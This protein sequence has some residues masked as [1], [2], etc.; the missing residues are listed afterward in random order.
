MN[1]TDHLKTTSYQERLDSKTQVSP[2]LQFLN[3]ELRAQVT[4]TVDQEYPSLFAGLP[5]GESLFIEREGQVV[6]HVGLVIRQFTHPFFRIKIGLLG[7]VVTRK[8]N[9]GEGLA[10]YLLQE[11]HRKLHKDQCALSIL[12]SDQPDFY[13]ALGFCRAGNEWDFRLSLEKA[14]EAPEVSRPLNTDCEIEA[15]WNLYQAKTAKIERTLEE[16][17]ALVNIPKTRIYVTE[18]N[19]QIDSYIAINKGADFTHYVHEWAGSVEAVKRNVLDCQNRFFSGFP[20]TL[21]APLEQSSTEFSRIAE[22]E[23]KGA[24]GLV[25]IVNRTNFLD[26]VESFFQ[27]SG[28]PLKKGHFENL[29]DEDL[30]LATLGRDGVP[31]SGTLPLFLWG[32]D[33]I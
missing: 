7:S 13:S 4:F 5:G 22:K 23:W 33:S 2:V 32:F 1:G 26:S 31:S 9:R 8:Q 17:V 10:S 3:Q 27:K 12:W 30:L 6:S 15:V 28:F 11:A 14:K 16:M 24:L 21:I 19:G 18:S 29:N 20:L 25:K